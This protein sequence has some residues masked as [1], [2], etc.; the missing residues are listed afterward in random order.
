MQ[1]RTPNQK[2]FS[3]GSNNAMNASSAIMP[4]SDDLEPV[5]ASGIRVAVALAAVTVLIQ[6]L[7]NGRYG[8]FRD[9]LYFFATSDRLAFGYVDFAPLSSF[10]LHVCRMVFGSSLHAIRLLPALA[11]GFNVYVTGL[12][13]RE[14]DGRRF[15]TLL[16]C[17]SVLLAPV[18]S[19]STTRYSMNAFEPLFW[20]GCAYFVIVAIRRDQ[21]RLL[22]WCGLCSASDWRISTR[23]PSSSLPSP[24]DCSSPAS[25]GCWVPNS[26]GWLRCWSR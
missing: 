15:A 10:I 20:M 11:F 26:S 18:I 6:M 5:S 25:V 1:A 8:Y 9:E 16:A 4:V 22:L 3:L 21:L 24:Q 12:I 2:P 17:G 14:L 7:T 13:V 23:L 19:G